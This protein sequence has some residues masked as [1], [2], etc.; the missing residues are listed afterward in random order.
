MANLVRK[1]EAASSCLKQKS[2]NLDDGK[3]HDGIF[4]Y[5][6]ILEREAAHICCL[7]IFQNSI[8]IK[9]RPLHASAREKTQFFNH[10]LAKFAEEL[11]SERSLEEPQ[12]SMEP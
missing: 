11:R 4:L 8:S 6:H 2:L 1:L 9:R 7:L 12:K 5:V 10:L 3:K